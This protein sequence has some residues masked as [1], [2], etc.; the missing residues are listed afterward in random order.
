VRAPVERRAAPVALVVDTDGVFRAEL[1]HLLG[2]AGYRLLEARTEGA[3]YRLLQGYTGQV[4]KVVVR[5]L[6]GAPDAAALQRLR[7][8]PALSKARG[9]LVVPEYA[10]L[11]GALPAGVERLPLEHTSALQA[12]QRL[13]QAHLPGDRELRVHEA[14][15]FF[16][17]VQYRE[18]GR[19]P[20]WR[21]G[22]SHDMS[23]GGLFMRTLVP[24]RVG[25]ALELRIFLTTTGEMLEGSGV[26]A[27]SNPWPLGQGLL[28]PPG[29]G[30]EFLGMSP[31]RLAHLREICRAA[32]F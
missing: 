14:V 4:D 10:A 9:L 27:W 21:C 16:C 12:F 32:S 18:L 19:E 23:P 24:P 8:M 22:Y 31:K 2:L 20:H 30:I 25:A 28:A 15:P 7:G 29:M 26:V 13:D 17:P 5:G 3:A 1:E 6:L 11:P